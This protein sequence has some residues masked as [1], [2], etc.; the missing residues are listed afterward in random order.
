MMSGSSDELVD[1]RDEGQRGPADRQQDRVRDLRPVGEQE[2]G[3]GPDEDREDHE[4]AV[5]AC[6][7]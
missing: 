1:A 4:V 2:E 6:G 3:A 5:H 7:D